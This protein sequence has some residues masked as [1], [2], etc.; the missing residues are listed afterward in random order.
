MNVDQ[1]I[2]AD[3]LLLASFL[4]GEAAFGIDAQLVQEVVKIGDITPVHHAPHHVVGIRNLR[5]RI[6]TV[7]DLATRLELG[8]A[9]ITPDSRILIMEWKSEPIGFLVDSVAETITT[10]LEDIAP[11]P[12]NLGGV[13][14]RNLRGV[15]RGGHRLVGVLDPEALMS[16]DELA[17]QKST[18]ERESL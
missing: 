17:N 5:G 11:P 2:T 7:I 12:P 6:V 9:K 1:A 14:S 15:C 10:R 13:Q 4:L 3:G 18:K 8:N 16:I